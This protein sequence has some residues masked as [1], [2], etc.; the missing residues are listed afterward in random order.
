MRRVTTAFPWFKIAL[1]EHNVLLAWS[2]VVIVA[3]VVDVPIAIVFGVVVGTVVVVV[4]VVIV[5]VVSGAIAVVDIVGGGNVF[6]NF[7]WTISINL[8]NG[9]FVCIVLRFMCNQIELLT[10]FLGI[11]LT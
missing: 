6:V 5:V 7:S 4:G 10:L 11:S 2:G 1:V 9:D 3:I 8:C